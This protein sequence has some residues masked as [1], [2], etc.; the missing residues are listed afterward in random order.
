MGKDKD[1][2]REI[3]VL[4]MVAVVVFGVAFMIGKLQCVTDFEPFMDICEKKGMELSYFK[5]Q[6]NGDT[7]AVCVDKTLPF[8]QE[9][10]NLTF[11]LYEMEERT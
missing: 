2:A 10:L 3:I 1:L 5:V 11:D 7:G 9:E 4:V 8:V 6:P